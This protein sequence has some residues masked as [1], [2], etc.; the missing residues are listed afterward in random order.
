VIPS[1]TIDNN[2]SPY[3]ELKPCVLLFAKSVLNVG[4]DGKTKII[5]TIEA[6]LNNIAMEYGISKFVL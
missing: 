4:K 5:N 1:S 6:I 3:K 2:T